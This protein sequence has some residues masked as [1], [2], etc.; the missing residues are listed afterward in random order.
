MLE[1]KN[2]NVSVEDKLILK[3]LN[4]SLGKGQVHAIMGPNG[5]GKSTIAHTLAGKPNYDVNS[6][7]V[8]FNGED[9]LSKDPYERSLDGL[10]LAFQYPIEL[11]GVTNASYLKQIV[12]AHRK[13]K[14][15]TPIDAGEFLK[16]LKEKSKQ[17]D[18]PM[19]MH[20]RFVN[21]G[22]SGGE[23]KKN[24]VLQMDLLDPSLIIM[25][26]TDSGL[27]VDALKSTAEAIN[28]LRNSD[29]TFLIITHYLRLLEYIE[30]DFVHVFQ[31]GSVIETG[32]KSL[33]SKI[34]Q[35]G[36]N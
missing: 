11:P 35:E 23:K 17:L 27:D 4:L 31:N 10:F 19:D 32:D 14:N 18:I 28:K 6:G 16:I 5:S 33:A 20:S 29:R 9:L 24:E 34:D 7:E 15:E 8:S 1:I 36:Y 25:D 21:T 2:L 22:F 26:E 12:N 13:S 30:P 3:N